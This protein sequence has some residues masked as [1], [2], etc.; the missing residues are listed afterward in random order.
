[1]HARN[2]ASATSTNVRNIR[3]DEF[4]LQIVDADRGAPAREFTGDRAA[5]AHAQTGNEDDMIFEAAWH[6]ERPSG[7]GDVGVDQGIRDR[8]THGMDVAAFADAADGAQM[9]MHGD[10]PGVALPP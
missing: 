10:I 5:D 4:R 8:A 2:G 9:A 1:M 3:V 7:G 6:C